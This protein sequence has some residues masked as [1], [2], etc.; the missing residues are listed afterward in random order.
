MSGAFEIRVVLNHTD[1]GCGRS[2]RRLTPNGVDWAQ[3]TMAR[4][5]G[6]AAL[7]AAACHRSDRFVP[8]PNAVFAGLFG[9]IEGVVGAFQER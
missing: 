1:N 5:G 3:P 2:V 4:A 8:E 7:I 6:A 9:R